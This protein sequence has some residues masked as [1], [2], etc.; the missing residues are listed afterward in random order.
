MTGLLY[1]DFKAIRGH[2]NLIGILSFTIILFVLKVFFCSEEIDII[3]ALLLTASPL[4][5]IG[6]LLTKMEV[7]IVA[8]D[9]EKNAQLYLLS[10]PISSKTYIASKY[11]FMFIGNYVIV[12]ICML[13]GMI[14]RIQIADEGMEELVTNIISLLPPVICAVLC[15]IAIELPFFVLLGS[16]RGNMIKTGLLLGMMLGIIVFLLFGDLTLL[17]RLDIQKFFR[18][19]EEHTELLFKLQIFSPVISIGL[20]YL[21]YLVTCSIFERKEICYES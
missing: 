15:L 10:L 4:I 17:D 5:M 6:M 9:E 18:F 13:W 19:L 11:W 3:L 7:G 8:A 21:S 14:Y 1:K 12:S 20:Y 2:Y 16:K